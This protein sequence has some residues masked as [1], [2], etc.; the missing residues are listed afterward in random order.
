MFRVVNRVVGLETEYGALVQDAELSTEAW[1]ARVKNYIFRQ[2]RAGAL[3]KHY[4]DYEEPPGNGGFLLNGGRLYLDMGHLEY[5]TPECRSVRDLVAHDLAGD[6][7]LHT[8]VEEM[9]ATEAVSF[10]KNNIDHHT[11][12]TFGCHENYLMRRDV[13]FHPEVVGTLLAFLATRQIF[14]GAG[15]VGQAR[16]LSFEFEAMPEEP[17]VD[18]QISQRA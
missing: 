15:R 11:G 12:A 2:A 9:H 16:P 3:D 4:R 7:M 1:P 13:Q 17:G 10:L 18:F 14:T 8:A 6:A 5:A